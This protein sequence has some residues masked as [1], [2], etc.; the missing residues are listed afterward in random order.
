MSLQASAIMFGVLWTA[1]MLWWSAPLELP[2]VV[3]WSAA[4]VL[5]A[6]AWYGLMSL[7]LKVRAK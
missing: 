1:G 4:G 2:Q 6:L 3:I 7:W 5:A